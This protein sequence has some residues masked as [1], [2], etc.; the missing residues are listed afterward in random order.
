MMCNFQVSLI[1][2][3]SI[4]TKLTQLCSMNI[5]TVG[6][7]CFKDTVLIQ[8]RRLTWNHTRKIKPA[9]NYI[10]YLRVHI[11]VH[12]KCSSNAQVRKLMCICL[13]LIF[14][15]SRN[16]EKEMLKNKIYEIKLRETILRMRLFF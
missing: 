9:F 12:S 15:V 13:W 2:K 14:L 4:F 6:T 5:S 8:T 1:Q 16:Y 3:K 10:V 7:I 11:K